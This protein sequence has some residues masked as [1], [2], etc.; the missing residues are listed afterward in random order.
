MQI[1]SEI[2]TSGLKELEKISLIAEKN[3]IFFE[4]LQLIKMGNDTLKQPK[5]KIY[6]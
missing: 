6:Q 3:T 4:N 5:E 2:V 1:P